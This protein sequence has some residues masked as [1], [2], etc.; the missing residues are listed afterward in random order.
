MDSEPCRPQGRENSTKQPPQSTHSFFDC[1]SPELHFD[2]TSEFYDH[3]RVPPDFRLVQLH[4]VSTP[5][6]ASKVGQTLG[7]YQDNSEEQTCPCC[8]YPLQSQRFPLLVDTKEL[9]ELGEGFPLYFD[10]VRWLTYMT[11]LVLL[12]A[13][14]LCLVQNYEAEHITEHDT[15][16][17]SNL[18][19]RGTLA[20]FGT[21]PRTSLV[22]P[23]VHVAALWL[24]LFADHVLNVRHKRLIKVL[25]FAMITPSDYTVMVK[26]LPLELNVE[27]LSRFLEV[28]GRPVDLM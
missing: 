20:S 11:V 3:Y 15:R 24:L 25:D 27:E 6:R 9:S 8:N 4:A 18:M 14:V 5:Q 12:V 19:L 21:Q 23:W 16:L 28:N 10:M 13:G 2:P 26:N 17:D 1:G 7:K 22:Q